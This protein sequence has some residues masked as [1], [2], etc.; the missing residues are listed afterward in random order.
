M[1]SMRTMV[2]ALAFRSA[3]TL[4]V[5]G[6]TPRSPQRPIGSIINVV[7]IFEWN[8]V[9]PAA[10]ENLTPLHQ[11]LIVYIMGQ[12]GKRRPSYTHAHRR[13]NLNCDQFNAELQ[14][15]YSAIRHYL[16]RFGLTTS[17]DLDE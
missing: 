14:Y 7:M 15:A 4:R 13:W 9:L 17:A 10:I 1:E 6:M 8:E 2:A 12:P 11:E 5:I 16:R 3:S